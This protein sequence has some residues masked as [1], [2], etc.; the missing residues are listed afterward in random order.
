M[1]SSMAMGATLSKGSVDCAEPVCE[2]G[3]MWRT[4]T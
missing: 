1:V 3:A 4:V 2:A